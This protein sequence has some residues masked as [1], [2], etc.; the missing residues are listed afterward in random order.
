MSFA[1]GAPESWQRARTAARPPRRL[2]PCSAPRA[3]CETGTVGS[4]CSSRWCPGRSAREGGRS[5]RSALKRSSAYRPPLQVVSNRSMPPCRA[6]TVRADVALLPQ[7]ILIA[8]SLKNV[9][10]VPFHALQQHRR[11]QS[12]QGGA[13]FQPRKTLSAS[14]LTARR[15]SAGHALIRK[16]SNR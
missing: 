10:L 16:G 8:I 7:R 12:L 6:M 9:S 13:T 1:P 2:P 15:T 5:K 4:S 14:M 3:A 11:G